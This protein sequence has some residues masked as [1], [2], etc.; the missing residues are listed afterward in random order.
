MTTDSV[1][2]SDQFD[3]PK[4]GGLGIN[5]QQREYAFIKNFDIIVVSS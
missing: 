5:K 4:L 2:L 1:I 3:K